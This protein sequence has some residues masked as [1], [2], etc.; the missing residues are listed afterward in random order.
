MISI[1]KKIA[2]ILV[3]V[4]MLLQCVPHTSFAS[5]DAQLL[6]NESF[7]GFVTNEVPSSLSIIGNP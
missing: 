2:S 1:N 3:T 4:A 7:N 5:D 6:V